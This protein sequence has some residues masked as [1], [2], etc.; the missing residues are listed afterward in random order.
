MVNK[1][2]KRVARQST[3][4]FP[5][6]T[7]REMP[8]PLPR[9]KRPQPDSSKSPPSATKK[10]KGTPKAIGKQQPKKKSTPQ[11]NDSS[12]DSY[13]SDASQSDPS[14]GSDSEYSGEE[15]SYTAPKISKVAKSPKTPSK[16]LKSSK[17]STPA[18]SKKTLA[19]PDQIDC[20]IFSNVTETGSD[21][22]SIANSWI[23]KYCSDN[24]AAII[25]FCNFGLRIAGCIG[26][27]LPSDLVSAKTI[28]DCLDRIKVENNESD[29][30]L[31]LLVFSRTKISKTK[32][33]LCLD[34]IKKLISLGSDV[35]L[36][37]DRDDQLENVF[38]ETS[39]KQNKPSLFLRVSSKWLETLSKSDYRPFRKVGTL[40]FFNIKSAACIISKAIR[41]NL[42]SLNKQLD[43]TKR[44][45]K[46]SKSRN[47]LL[48]EQISELQSQQNFIKSEFAFVFDRIFLFRYLDVSPDIRTDCVNYLV[49]WTLK[50]T[51][52]FL[53]NRFLKYL[54]WLWN[55]S[56]SKVR[57]AAIDGVRK[58]VDS[59]TSV[60]SQL[61]S[62]FERFGPRL[63]QLAVADIDPNI[64][65]AALKLVLKV[66]DN[67]M[68][69]SDESRISSAL[70]EIHNQPASVSEP[71]VLKTKKKKTKKS[72]QKSFSQQLI[73]DSD[74]ST[75]DNDSDTNIGG[76]S[77]K[78]S[79]NIPKS[80][81]ESSLIVD[82]YSQ[83]NSQIDYPSDHVLRY[84][85]PLI[86]HSQASVRSS[87][88]TLIVWWIR[89]SWVPMFLNSDESVDDTD[90]NNK[91]NSFAFYK[92]ISSFLNLI[93]EKK[94]KIINPDLQDHTNPP[95]QNIALST[96]EMSKYE[97]SLTHVKTFLESINSKS[98][99]KPSFFSEILVGFGNN[100][101]KL[102]VSAASLYGKSPDFQN[103]ESLF[104]FLALD[105]SDSIISE[106]VDYE[107]NL[108]PNEESA[109]LKSSLVWIGASTSSLYSKASL[110]SVGSSAKSNIYSQISEIFVGFSKNALI[111]L[112][113]YRNQPEFLETLL[114]ISA[115][116]LYPQYFFDN[117][118]M[119]E[120]ESIVEILGHIFDVLPDNVIVC[121][122][123]IY[124]LCVIDDS[125]LLQMTSDDLEQGFVN[126]SNLIAEIE[127]DDENLNEDDDADQNSETKFKSVIKLPIG[128]EVG[129]L[130]K[131]VVQNSFNIILETR[132]QNDEKA[133]A[134]LFYSL[135]RLKSIS[136]YKNISVCLTQEPESNKTGQNNS[137]I[138]SAR[139]SD[140]LLLLSSDM[141]FPSSEEGSGSF[142]TLVTATSLNLYFSLLCWKAFNLIQS[143][144]QISEKDVFTDGNYNQSLDKI[145]SDSKNIVEDRDNFLSTCYSHL[146]SP[147]DDATI[148]L[149]CLI[150]CASTFQLFSYGLS[151]NMGKLNSQQVEFRSALSLEVPEDKLVLWARICSEV[152]SNWSNT[153]MPYSLSIYQ[154][155]KSV[156]GKKQDRIIELGLKHEF[157]QN[158]NYHN[159]F[160][161]ELA[162]SFSG[163]IRSGILPITYC[164]ALASFTGRM[165]YELILNEYVKEIEKEVAENIP[166][167]GVGS[168]DENTDVELEQTND[169]LPK[170]VGFVSM[171]A[172]DN[173]IFDLLESL[174]GSLESQQLC[175]FMMKECMKCLQLNYET[176]VTNDLLMDQR[177]PKNYYKRQL[178]I[179]PKMISNILKSSGNL[180]GDTLKSPV[181]KNVVGLATPVVSSIWATLHNNFVK[182]G[183]DVI[184]MCSV[185][186]IPSLI[187]R[188]KPSNGDGDAIP[189]DKKTEKELSEQ[190]G[191]AFEMNSLWYEMLALTV[192]GL[193]RPK[194]AQIIKNTIMGQAEAHGL[195][196]SEQY[197]D[198]DGGKGDKVGGKKSKQKK[199]KQAEL[200]K[201]HA[202]QLVESEGL[203][204]EKAYYSSHVLATIRPYMKRL[205]EQ[206]EKLA[207]VQ[208][209]FDRNRKE[210]NVSMDISLTPMKMVTPADTPVAN[211]AAN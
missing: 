130:I 88:A 104:D 65:S 116:A 161:I 155:E 154:F 210:G 175:S 204:F 140:K 145:R 87:A 8:P 27:V 109:L 167:N 137:E 209:M 187:E 206:I 61:S 72:S 32:L 142:E 114:A 79:K 52:T 57:L 39:P 122:L 158:C 26:S 149:T 47:S 37:G 7:S 156:R 176:F 90:E 96:K 60:A 19:Q 31:E 51:P 76:S 131:R 11:N 183:F 20:E 22:D 73:D 38:A 68:L 118:K 171:S 105:H 10:H 34:F 186:S 133:N 4:Q 66:A 63:I 189:R 28:E 25:E 179:L 24:E 100:S 14:G 45:S 148:L 153:L 120:L 163:L 160:V 50:D 188:L 132:G 84:L 190:I 181:K 178:T 69:I 48:E 9:K 139:V 125:K 194:H 77:S 113:R 128:S 92:S 177:G 91:F 81:N 54:G 165:G 198:V 6:A 29:Q 13:N 64:I 115:I 103:S 119:N 53:E 21:L 1:L 106:G 146:N 117:K 195:E 152:F 168:G 129:P 95:F 18:A 86:T 141:F 15:E 23:D 42:S 207:L 55:D 203:S 16:K 180:A 94:E 166:E 83:G 71:E 111:L 201:E 136:G 49:D 17:K 5:P 101:H 123:I 56:D 196:I 143:I 124:L 121:Q 151:K 46:K 191:T 41:E 3:I 85:S 193:I 205:D 208:E 211:R 107:V 182:Y 99:Q 44:S 30:R 134:N 43:L 102:A 157:L 62:F 93:D 185:D 162:K 174:K 127:D 2:R 80:I 169:S 89:K 12:D 97:D 172:F 108:S 170:L 40:I 135:M 82:L 202:D 36:F 110:P 192:N 173:V 67:G 200:I 197:L 164:S 159:G 112:T 138:N 199:K 147:D 150:N 75:S 35:L 144:S 184:E 98:S 70:S 58:I 126:T 33:S 59:S 78:K 74:D